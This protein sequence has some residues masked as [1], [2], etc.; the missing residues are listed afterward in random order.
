MNIFV[1]EEFPYDF[2]QIELHQCHTGYVY[3]LVS[4][5]D[6]RKTCIGQTFDERTII[7]HIIPVWELFLQKSIDHWKFMVT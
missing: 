2:N 4:L 6:N 1:F 5:K 7:K 3:F